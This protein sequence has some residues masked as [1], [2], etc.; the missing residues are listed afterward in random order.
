M[1]EDPTVY[2]NYSDEFNQR[3]SKLLREEFN[4]YVP[5]YLDLHKFKKETQ[6]YNKQVLKAAEQWMANPAMHIFNH[7][8]R[9][10]ALRQVQRVVSY[11]HFLNAVG[12]AIRTLPRIEDRPQC[13]IPLA[14]SPNPETI[15]QAAKVATPPTTPTVTQTVTLPQATM[16]PTATV[17]PFCAVSTPGG[18]S[19]IG[20]SVSTPSPHYE[21]DTSVGDSSILSIPGLPTEFSH[22]LSATL[23]RA[24]SDTTFE[25]AQLTRLQSFLEEA[26]R[27]VPTPQVTVATRPGLGGQRYPAP[28]G[29]STPL[30]AEPDTSA[31]VLQRV[32]RL[33][34]TVTASST[35]GTV[36]TCASQSLVVTTASTTTTAIAPTTVTSSLSSRPLS[37]PR[38]GPVIDT[39]PRAPA[40][41]GGIAIPPPSPSVSALMSQPAPASTRSN[42]RP[43]HQGASAAVSQ[44]VE[45]PPSQR[46]PLRPSHSASVPQMNAAQPQQP[47]APGPLHQAAAGQQPQA[48][49]AAAPLPRVEVAPVPRRARRRAAQDRQPQNELERLR[50]VEQR[51]LPSQFIPVVNRTGLSQDRLR[52]EHDLS[53][54]G[55]FY[56]KDGAARPRFRYFPEQP[57]AEQET[58]HQSNT[59]EARYS[60]L[61]RH[62]VLGPD[63][64]ARCDPLHVKLRNAVVTIAPQAWQ[65]FL[66]V[67]SD[68]HLWDQW[69]SM[70]GLNGF[71]LCPPEHGFEMQWYHESSPRRLLPYAVQYRPL[72]NDLKRIVRGYWRRYASRM[73]E[74]ERVGVLD[75]NR[76]MQGERGVATDTSNYLPRE[77]PPQFVFDLVSQQWYTIE[78]E[79]PP[80]RSD[81]STYTYSF[82][83]LPRELRLWLSDA[84][85]SQQTW[86]PAMLSQNALLRRRTK[87]WLRDAQ[88]PE[89]VLDVEAEQELFDYPHTLPPSRVSPPES[90]QLDV[91]PQHSQSRESRTPGLPTQGLTPS[92]RPSTDATP[93][94]SGSVLWCDALRDWETTLDKRSWSAPSLALPT[95]EQVSW[96]V[97]AYLKDHKGPHHVALSGTFQ[98]FLT[99]YLVS[100]VTA[101]TTIHPAIEHMRFFLTQW[102]QDHFLT[103]QPMPQDLIQQAMQHACTVLKLPSHSI[104]LT[105]S[106]N[107]CSV[108]RFRFVFRFPTVTWRGI[109]HNALDAM[110]WQEADTWNG[111][112]YHAAI[113]FEPA[114][115]QAPHLELP[116]SWRDNTP[117]LRRAVAILMN[118]VR[119]SVI[120]QLR[121]LLQVFPDSA[122]G[123]PFF[124]ADTPLS[125]HWIPPEPMVVHWVGSN[126]RFITSEHLYFWLYARFCLLPELAEA[127]IRHRSPKTVK[128]EAERVL[129]YSPLA[130]YWYAFFG[131][132][133]MYLIVR[134]KFLQYPLVRTALAEANL[135]ILA[136]GSLDTVWAVGRRTSDKYVTNPHYWTG[137]NWLGL[138]WTI[139]ANQVLDQPTGIPAVERAHPS[140]RDQAPSLHPDAIRE[141]FGRAAKAERQVRE[142]EPFPQ[143]FGGEPAVNCIAWL[144]WAIRSPTFSLQSAE[145]TVLKLQLHN[146]TEPLLA[147]P[148][149]PRA[150]TNS[151]RRHE[152]AS[153]SRSN[154]RA[155]PT[156]S[157]GASP[158]AARARIANVSQADQ[159]STATRPSARATQG[160]VPRAGSHQAA[161]QQQL[162]TLG[163]PSPPNWVQPFPRADVAQWLDTQPPE[164]NNPQYYV[165]DSLPNQAQRWPSEQFPSGGL[166]PQPTTVSQRLPPAVQPPVAT[167]PYQLP[168]GTSLFPAESHS[169]PQ[170]PPR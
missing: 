90:E 35:A 109:L 31:S 95:E 135:L 93:Y 48:D 145:L 18:T 14:M 59:L 63:F 99:L 98:P 116:Y 139:L 166:L 152:R 112:L 2:P 157:S 156:R 114:F 5:D 41:M 94:Q 32:A 58:S 54:I 73:D 21:I 106:G 12:E 107:W 163:Q 92:P 89:V 169:Y 124:T 46:R 170:Y 88:Q 136:E 51:L 133:Y 11:E 153:R 10:D 15:T 111:G 148:L 102:L 127:L 19:G 161:Y 17:P 57:P 144:L 110:S 130:Y 118:S 8:L 137:T 113:F 77:P 70:P 75:Y 52:A 143:M 3:L 29:T 132:V 55:R 66:R 6:I 74:A 141:A 25:P 125:N 69:Y 117:L 33:S 101:P 83:P 1:V 120:P 129:K 24:A 142:I 151:K 167:P 56:T 150:A 40:R 115:L 67:P 138:V 30:T 123:Y 60:Q 159:A 85:F 23:N 155:P 100:A 28:T 103:G 121:H 36:S 131:P 72:P 45:P 7:K 104:I 53:L 37:A 164:L 71:K 147:A 81:G 108:N 49:A 13:T 65:I 62:N 20:Q 96:A 128:V 140:R 82:V 122:V 86:P 47:A 154:T 162:Q 38:S 91:A 26:M 42:D 105:P 22:I 134:E 80:V 9:R 4:P 119:L 87:L 16:A 44:A 27:T 165:Q 76:R 50:G 97:L 168:P 146:L 78:W 68:L 39:E 160:A 84:D 149:S 79:Y 126:K 43:S 34:V 158:P 64:Q 61:E